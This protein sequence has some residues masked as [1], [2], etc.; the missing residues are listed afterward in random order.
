MS[1]ALQ[2]RTQ[3]DPSRKIGL[4]GR[5]PGRASRPGSRLR[6]ATRRRRRT[7]GVC[8]CWRWGSPAGVGLWDGADAPNR[9]V[10]AGGVWARPNVSRCARGRLHT[11]ARPARHL[12]LVLSPTKKR[13]SKLAKLTPRPSRRTAPPLSRH[14]PAVLVADASMWGLWRR[15]A[16]SFNRNSAHVF[17]AKAEDAQAR[18]G[19]NPHRRAMRFRCSGGRNPVARKLGLSVALQT[20]TA[21]H[22]DRASSPRNEHPCSIAEHSR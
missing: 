4:G 15:R 11:R 7:V 22:A 21:R 19:A 9:A 10:S 3:V 20:A 6:S 2:P 1:L 18:P 16:S 13:L 5:S 8:T 17:P 14:R 12:L